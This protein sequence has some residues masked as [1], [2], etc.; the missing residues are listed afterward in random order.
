MDKQET[1]LGCRVILFPQPFI[2]HVTPML[3]LGNALYSKGFSITIIH[4][5]FN[6]PDPAKYPNF[7]FR[8]I[9]DAQSKA[10]VLPSDP[11]K[12]LISLN[13]SCLAPFRN[14][15]S[16]V[17][18]EASKDREPIACLILDPI[19]HFAAAIADE[20][21]LPR[22]ALRTGGT[23][24]FVLYDMLPLLDEKGYFPIQGTH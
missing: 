19:W 22:I 16:Q 8:Y 12:A 21:N 13:A 5:H 4:T 9:E 24:A 20:F 18:D 11:L 2:G 17:L 7:T 3:Y 6:A 23:L 1:M 10:Q 14:C 15:L